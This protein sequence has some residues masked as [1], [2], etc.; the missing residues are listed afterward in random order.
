[1][2]FLKV[3]ILHGVEFS[4]FLLRF[5]QALQS[6]ALWCRLWRVG[7]V[8]QLNGDWRFWDKRWCISL[9]SVRW[10]LSLRIQSLPSFCSKSNKHTLQKLLVAIP[11]IHN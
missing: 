9:V 7:H 3:T 10:C 5:A 1:M 8:T 11:T 6:V 4:N 2:K